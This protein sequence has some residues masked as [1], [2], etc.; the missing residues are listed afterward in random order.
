MEFWLTRELWALRQMAGRDAMTVA[1][2]LGRS[3]RAVQDMARCQG[4]QV[5]RQPHALYWP[6]TTER[7]TRQ[8]QASGNTVNQTSVALG[9]LFGTVCRWVYE[10]AAA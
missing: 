7:R 8:L 4:M 3:P 6:A 9:V 2:A 10:G 1:A 5:P